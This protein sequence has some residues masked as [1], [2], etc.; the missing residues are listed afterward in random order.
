MIW[1]AFGLKEVRNRNT[2]E[3]TLKRIRSVAVSRAKDV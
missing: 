3:G 1:K 2:V